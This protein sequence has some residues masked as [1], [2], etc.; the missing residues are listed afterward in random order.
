MGNALEGRSGGGQGAD[1]RTFKG[2]GATGYPRSLWKEGE[3]GLPKEGSLRSLLIVQVKRPRRK[4]E[5][6]RGLI[7]RVGD[8]SGFT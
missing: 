1:T 2:H 5:R 3:S 7:N 4:L 8:D 6:W